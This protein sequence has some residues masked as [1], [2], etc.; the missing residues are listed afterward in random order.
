MLRT[1]YWLIDF[2]IYLLYIF[3]QA[4][5]GKRMEKAGHTEEKRRFTQKT[6]Q[7]WSSRLLRKTGSHIEVTGSEHVPAEGPVLIVS[8]HQ[9]YM[10][11]P[12][13][14]SV[15]PLPMGFVAKQELRRLPVI[16]RW[17]DLIE[18]SYIDRKDI[19]QSLR[20]IQ[21]AQKSLESGQSMVIFPE[22]T[23]S[24]SREIGAFKPGSLKLAQKAGIPI[25]PVAI[26]GSY[27]IYEERG[28]I[29]ATTV[30][31][32][33]LPLIPAETVVEESS[34]DL[35]SRVFGDIR[36]ALGMEGLLSV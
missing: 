33:I 17:M 11:I 27:R 20:A 18:C 21:Q 35:M 2:I 5:R 36:Q 12:L 23:R 34:S 10:D 6:G 3:V 28:R 19:R 9:S 8:N 14:V 4:L 25:L 7:I 15:V 29:T 31:V 24:K 22:G 32:T 13:M 30:K 26:D 1:I 16:S